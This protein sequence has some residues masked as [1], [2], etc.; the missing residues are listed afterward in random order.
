MVKKAA[1]KKPAAAVNKKPA[2]VPTT[3]T[4]ADH[5]YYQT[6]A[7]AYNTYCTRRIPIMF[8]ELNG[9]SGWLAG[10]LA[11]DDTCIGG[12]CFIRLMS[13]GQL[14]LCQPLDDTWNCIGT[15]T[16]LGQSYG[17]FQSAIVTSIA[18]GVSFQAQKINPELA[19]DLDESDDD[20]YVVLG[21]FLW[22]PIWGKFVGPLTE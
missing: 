20:G 12:P 17:G 15:E 10:E 18:P 21:A 19:S 6:I 4:G 2:A 5:Q 22:G 1:Q 16:N 7:T 8:M 11:E 9:T 3:S 14:K 13:G